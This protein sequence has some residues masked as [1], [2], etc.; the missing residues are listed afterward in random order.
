LA[1]WLPMPLLL[2]GQIPHKPGV[3]TVF[4]QHSYLPRAGKQTEST[5]SDNV[6]G[7]TDNMPKGETRRYPPAK[8]RVSTPQTS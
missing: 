8:A 1:A 6:T 5:H 3:P 2:H 4:G 7:A